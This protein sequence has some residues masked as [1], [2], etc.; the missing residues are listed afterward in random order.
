MFKAIALSTIVAMFTGV[1]MVPAIS[2]IVSKMT[3]DGTEFFGPLVI[4][5]V[6]LMCYAGACAV[7]YVLIA[8][9]Q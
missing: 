5:V 2:Q 6:L 8:G 7:S 3:Q 4:F 9:C 1:C